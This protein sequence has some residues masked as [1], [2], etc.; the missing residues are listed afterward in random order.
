M[1][2][3]TIEKPQGLTRQKNGYPYRAAFLTPEQYLTRERIA[4]HKSEY[5]D[6]EIIAMAG[7]SFEHNL[8]VGNVVTEL[9]LALRDQSDCY[10]SPSDLRVLIPATNHITYPDVVV[11]RGE[12]PQFMDGGFDMIRN[13]TVVVEV[14]PPSTE[15]YDRGDKFDNYQTI[16]SLREYVLVSQNEPKVQVFTGDGIGGWQ[17][18]TVT[19]LENGVSLGTLSVTLALSD[20][21]RRVSFPA[22]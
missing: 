5:R 21:Y 10:V 11:I 16:P 12:Q 8:I 4:Y 20:L 6:G 17:E 2:S 9:N 22:P 15:D 18:K 1:A 7:A 14:L 3:T 13:P 19:G